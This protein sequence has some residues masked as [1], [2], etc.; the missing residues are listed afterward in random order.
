MRSLALNRAGLAHAL[1]LAPRRFTAAARTAPLT[2]TLPTPNGGFQRF[3][4][5]N[6][7]V[8]APGLAARHPEITSYAGTG[9]DDPTANIRADLSPLGFHASVRSAHGNWY[10]EPASVSNQAT[11]VSYFGRDLKNAHGTFV[12]REA[13]GLADDAA[14]ST[15]RAGDQ[16]GRRSSAPTGSR[17]SATRRT[18]RTSVPTT[19]RRRRSC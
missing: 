18:R 4:V 1:S 10:V 9:I 19:S 14:A 15:P 7:P 2:L 6:A 13:G 8:M 12:E 11:Y 16:R 17:S 3:A 5:S